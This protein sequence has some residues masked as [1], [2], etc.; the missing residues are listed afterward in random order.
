MDLGIVVEKEGKLAVGVG[1]PDHQQLS[2]LGPGAYREAGGIPPQ[3]HAVFVLRFQLVHVVDGAFGPFRRVVAGQPGLPSGDENLDAVRL[4][5]AYAGGGID[6]AVKV[7][8]DCLRPV[9][10]HAA[11]RQPQRLGS[12]G[13]AVVCAQGG[14]VMVRAVVDRFL[15][16]VPQ[17]RKHIHRPRGHAVIDAPDEGFLV[18]GVGVGGQA[19][20]PDL[21][22]RGDERQE[23][24]QACVLR[25]GIH[26]LDAALHRSFG[27]GFKAGNKGVLPAEKHTVVLRF[28]AGALHAGFQ[29]QPAVTE[30]ELVGDIVFKILRKAAGEKRTQ[31]EGWRL[32][33]H[34]VL[35]FAALPVR[36]RQME[37]RQQH[38]EDCKTED[39]G[40]NA[41][42]TILH[43]IPQKRK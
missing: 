16:V 14:P 33:Q 22:S 38:K 12:G 37:G 17:R 24:G 18:G 31:A 29:V 5:P 30:G 4:Y 20:G 9:A 26:G 7:C 11:G 28:A 6:R 25:Q 10:V 2:A 19:V 42:A 1:I 32:G 41:P 39:D 35:V 40:Q 23:D 21:R 34:A 13:I 43:S 3:E 27:W 36:Q 8:A 15:R